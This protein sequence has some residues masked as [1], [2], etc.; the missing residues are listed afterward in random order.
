M[1][2]RQGLPQVRARAVHAQRETLSIVE[3]HAQQ[4]HGGRVPGVRRQTAQP[5][6]GG[7]RPES[8]REARPAVEQGGRS[9]APDQQPFPA[10]VDVDDVAR[11]HAAQGAH[12]RSAGEEESHLGE[13]EAQIVGQVGDDGPQNALEP[14]FAS[15]ADGEQAEELPFLQ[16]IQSFIE[17]MMR[18]N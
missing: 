3:A 13:R 6:D 9:H 17:K 10:A 2:G 1:M 15:V 18:R 8:R 11:S 5:D 4:P 12:D 16:G 7:E 14:V